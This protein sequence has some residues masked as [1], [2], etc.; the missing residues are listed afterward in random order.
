MPINDQPIISRPITPSQHAVLDYAVALSFLAMAFRFRRRNPA[1]SMLACLNGSL[2]LGVAMV[3]DYPGGLWPALGFK[4]HRIMDV[5]QAALAGCGPLLFGF[6]A[7]SEARAFYAQAAS[8][9]AVIAA[10]DWDAQPPA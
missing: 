9:V 1:A 4:T 3:T 5:G 7:T 2:V 8:E 6:A 10:T